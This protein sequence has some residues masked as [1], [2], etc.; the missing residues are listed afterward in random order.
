MSGGR[1]RLVITALIVSATA[2]LAIGGPVVADKLITGRDLAPGTIGSRELANGAVSGRKLSRAL[3]RSLQGRDGAAGRN[4]ANGANGAQGP[5]GPQGPQGAQGPAGAFNVVDASGRVLG[6]FAGF[7]SSGYPQVYTAAGAILTWD[8]SI[9]TNYP[10]N[11]PTTQLYY[12]LPGCAGTAYANYGSSYPF[13]SGIVLESPPVPGSAVY[14]MLPGTP[15]SFRYE[16]Y[17]TSSGCTTTS[18]TTSNQLPVRSAGTVPAVQKPLSL[19]PA[20]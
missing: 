5:Q 14:V 15:E 4:G 8:T 2:F 18:S 17:K 10:T 13:Q 16:S 9:G 12:K 7:Y 20:G 19:A 1:K 11:I 3:R 6:L